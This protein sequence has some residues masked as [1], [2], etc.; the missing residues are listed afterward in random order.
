MNFLSHNKM[1]TLLKRN[2]TGREDDGD[3]I[4]KL[5]IL[6]KAIAASILVPTIGL[7]N[8]VIAY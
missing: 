8:G 4:W 7:S 2:I 6:S 1:E 5:L 3:F